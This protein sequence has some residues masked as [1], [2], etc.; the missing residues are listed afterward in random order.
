MVSTLTVVPTAITVGSYVTESIITPP[1]FLPNTAGVAGAHPGDEG[2]PRTELPFH[3]HVV[4]RGTL[5]TL[6]H[7][8]DVPGLYVLQ[9]LVT[10]SQNQ[11][12][13]LRVTSADS[14]IQN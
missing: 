14:F 3:L 4:V 13:K 12:Y 10:V 6:Q 5:Q 8:R 11:P 7:Q 9:T 2:D 1:T